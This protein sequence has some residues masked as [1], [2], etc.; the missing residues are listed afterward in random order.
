MK[1]KIG[2][3]GSSV[4]E[5]K[6]AIRK[7]R[8]LGKE[9]SK[10]NTIVVTGACS[11]MPYIAAYEASKNGG[12]VWGFS[13]NVNEVSQIAMYKNDDIK[14]YNKIFYIPKN[15]K[16]LFFMKSDDLRFTELMSRQ[17][18]RN[19]I[20]TANCDAG[21]IISGRWGTLNEFTNLYDMGKIIGILTET[22]GIADEIE[23]LSKKI[24]KPSKAKLIFSSDSHELVKQVIEELDIIYS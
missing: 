6:E 9:L 16:N 2:V 22:G 21:I 4:N 18:Y 3:F 1:Y 5:N 15:Y 20:S 7:T 12:E 10:Q 13:P 11:G 8:Q 19:V 17:K 23:S 24:N 14:I